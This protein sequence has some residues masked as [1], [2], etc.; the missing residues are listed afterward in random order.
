MPAEFPVDCIDHPVAAATVTASV[1]LL[2][3]LLL[4]FLRILFI[5]RAISGQVLVLDAF[6]CVPKFDKFPYNC[7]QRIAIHSSGG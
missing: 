7:L 6:A 2:V 5:F 1:L 4:V 3:L